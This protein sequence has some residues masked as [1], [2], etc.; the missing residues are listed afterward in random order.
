V[1]IERAYIVLADGKIQPY[2]LEPIPE[3]VVPSSITVTLVAQTNIPAFYVVTSKG[4]LADTTDYN[5]RNIIVGFSNAA[6]LSGFEVKVIGS[7]TITNPAWSWTKGDKIFLNGAGNV[8]N[9]P[10]ASTYSV[11]LGT[12]TAPDTIDVNIQPSILL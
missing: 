7:G 2:M 6:A 8:S 5:T 3:P 10:P 11:I 9:I 1:V 4:Y 12:A